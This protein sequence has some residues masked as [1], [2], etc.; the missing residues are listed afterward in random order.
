M[1]E[2]EYRTLEELDGQNW[3]EPETAPTPM[4]ARCLRL[5]RTPL[6]LLRQSD[7]RLLIGQKIGLKYVVPKAMAI[8]SKDALIETE[9]FPGDLLCA[10]LKIDSD[11]WSQ[12]T[13]ELKWLMSVAQS[14]ANQ[15]GKIVGDCESFLAAHRSKLN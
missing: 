8:I 7:L 13:E 12:K 1:T 5:R 9:H 2:D 14:V 10:L 11:Y 3:G 15:Y 4:V 6:H